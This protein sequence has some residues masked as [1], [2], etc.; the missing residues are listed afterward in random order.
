MTTTDETTTQADRGRST[1]TSTAP[2]GGAGW[3]AVAGLVAAGAALAT[4]EVMSGLSLS[5]PS[6]LV[7]IFDV[8]VDFSPEG[9]VSWS[10]ETFGTNQKTVTITGITIVALLIGTLVGVLSR[11]DRRVG[12]A[13]FTAFGLL[14]GWAA[15]RTPTASPFWAWVSAL[16][17][18]SVGL[19][20]LTRLL[21]T[22][23]SRGGIASSADTTLPGLLGTTERRRFMGIAG[24]AAFWAVFGSGLGRSLRS[25]LSVESAREQ[26]AT[27][28]VKGGA[29]S[30]APALEGIETLDSIQGIS[31]LVTPS[32][33]FYRIDTAFSPPQVDPADWTLTIKG[34]VDREV[35]FTFDD[36]AAMDQITEVITLSCVSNEVGGRLVGNAVWGGVPLSTLLDMAGVQPGATQIVG[37]SVD[38]WTGGF[39]TEIAFDG[40]PAM[41]AITMNGEPLPIDHGFPARLVV[42]GLYGYVSAT[43]WLKEIELTTW[44]A[45]DGYWIPRGWAKEGP[46]K[47]QSRIDVPANGGRIAP[48]R[49]PIAGVAW[50]PHRSID[51]VEVRVDEGEWQEARLS[52]E[53]SINAWRQWV[54]EWDAAP[55]DHSIEVRATDGTGETQT[56][57]RTPVAPDGA[58]GH[59]RITVRV[60]AA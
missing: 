36:L 47:T 20:V 32:N 22:I 45:Y 12:V 17:A 1:D 34:M 11:R 10:R 18:M 42:P 40:R 29:G 51:T 24:G 38:D 21:R 59:H 4:G 35:S 50:A 54:L 26:I 9:I 48:G 19:W 5:I 7:S 8:L 33:V 49:T 3:A 27:D 13:T 46:I 14:G 30:T 37:R 53:P 58:T 39:P 41:V 44:E 23:P 2:A 6:L 31:P 16:A 60:E 52:G 55:G 43:K 56:E 25:G 28:L 57:E 15:A